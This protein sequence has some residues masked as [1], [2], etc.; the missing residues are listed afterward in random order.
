[1]GETFVNFVKTAAL[2][3]AFFGFVWLVLFAGFASKSRY[4]RTPDTTIK[5]AMGCASMVIVASILL[6]AVRSCT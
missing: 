6:T 3:S 4:S 2:A 5:Q 1:M